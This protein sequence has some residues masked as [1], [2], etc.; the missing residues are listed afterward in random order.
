MSVLGLHCGIMQPYSF[1]EKKNQGFGN[2]MGNF[3]NTV[4]IA[5]IKRFNVGMSIGLAI[6]KD[7]TYS[8]SILAL[9]SVLAI[10]FY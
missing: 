8:F 9:S 10:L 4:A 6:S 1:E 5:K 2:I 7:S 3:Q